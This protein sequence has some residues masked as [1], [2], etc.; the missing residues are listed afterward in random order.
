MAFMVLIW[1]FN[2]IV[3]KDAVTDLAPLAFNA[4]RFM[5]GP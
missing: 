4:L 5:A 3:I 1:G 2:F